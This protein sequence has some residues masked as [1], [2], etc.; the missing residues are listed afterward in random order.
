MVVSLFFAIFAPSLPQI[1]NMSARREKQKKQLPQLNKQLET[2]EKTGIKSRQLKRKLQKKMG[3]NSFLLGNLVFGG[4]LIGG[5]FQELNS[6]V[7]H[8]L[9]GTIVFVLFYMIGYILY[10]QGIKEDLK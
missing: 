5:I 9:I 3:D 10:K 6:P 1:V 4:V 8:F 7:L 2:P